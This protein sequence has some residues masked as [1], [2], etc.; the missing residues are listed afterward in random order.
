L[1]HTRTTLTQLKLVHPDVNASEDAARETQLLL[2]AFELLSQASVDDAATGAGGDDDPFASPEAPAS[3]VFVNELRCVG[4]RCSSSCVAKAPRVFAF[5][6]DTGAARAVAQGTGTE[7]PRSRS[8]PFS[9]PARHTGP[10]HAHTHAGG[11]G[12]Y[13]M[14]LA[15]GQCPTECIH[16]V[17]PRQCAILDALL[18][19]HAP[20]AWCIHVCMLAGAC[21]RC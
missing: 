10:S 3:A 15:V 17:T 19:R 14:R 9:A 13:A 5:A 1:Q 7:P 16:Y 12:E 21:G 6:D 18:L 2:R 8:L 11:E 4:R 20:S